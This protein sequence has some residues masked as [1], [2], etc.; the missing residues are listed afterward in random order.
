VDE[1]TESRAIDAS[2]RPATV[3]SL[4]EDLRALGVRDGAVV[5]V[6]S[7][8]SRLGYVAGGAHAVVLAL[9]NAVGPA[10]TIV[11]PTHSGDLSDP[12]TWSKPPVPEAWWDTIRS[13]MPAYDPVLTPT[14]RMGAIVECFRRLPGTRR[15]AHPTISVAAHGPQATT[16]ID[17][18]PLAYGLGEDSPLARL[19]ELDADVALLG[20]GHANNTSLHLAEY[21]ADYPNKAWT[22][23]G[24]PVFIDDHRAWTTYD[25]L[26]A[27]DSDFVPLG[28]SFASTGQEH[29]AAVGAGVGRFMRQR[30][31]VD[32]A[33]EWMGQHR[34]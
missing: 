14:R 17:P 20:V 11:V 3:G 2:D 5:M 28:E 10:G 25:D 19:Y 13:A 15:S 16:I 4:T 24:S 30:D 21:R 18:H 9:L 34:R 1:V 7:S 6:H 31:I 8:L 26:E 23:H 32:Y 22:T 29:R 12:A 33:V 27:D